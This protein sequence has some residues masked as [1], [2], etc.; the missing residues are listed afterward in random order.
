MLAGIG[1]SIVLIAMLFRQKFE[2]VFSALHI[3]ESEKEI[4][5]N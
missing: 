4:K 2:K 1:L 3:V 5:S